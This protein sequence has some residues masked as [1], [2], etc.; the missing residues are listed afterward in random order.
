[1]EC[2]IIDK[3]NILFNVD[4]PKREE[5]IRKI[6]ENQIKSIEKIQSVLKYKKTAKKRLNNG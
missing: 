1:M 6:L 2:V 5:E 3:D 4:D